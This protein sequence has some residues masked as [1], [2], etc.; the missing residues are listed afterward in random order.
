[1][2]HAL[3]PASLQGRVT[4]HHFPQTKAPK[5]PL[6]AWTSAVTCH[7][8]LV[9]TFTPNHNQRA[10]VNTRLGSHPPLLTACPGLP[11]SRPRSTETSVICPRHLLALT[12]SHAPPWIIPAIPASSLK[13]TRQSLASVPLHGL[14]SPPGTPFPGTSFPTTPWLLPQLLQFSAQMSPP[15]GVLPWPLWKIL[16]SH[17]LVPN[18]SCLSLRGPV[19]TH[20]SGLSFVSPR[21]CEPHQEQGFLCL[22]P[23]RVLS[24]QQLLE[25]YG[26]NEQ[27]NNNSDGNEMERRALHARHRVGAAFVS[28]T[29]HSATFAASSHIAP[30]PIFTECLSS[31]PL[32]FLKDELN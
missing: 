14:S 12:S 13:L 11:K 32:W 1:M 6:L 31:S 22:V 10:P 17:S 2:L 7:W 5:P 28:S 27:T 19:L 26:F 21:D 24:T 9:P 15:Q 3:F 8:S 20:S 23:A 16:T 25:K 29:F 4:P 18:L 30:K